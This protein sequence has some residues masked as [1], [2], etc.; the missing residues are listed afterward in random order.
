[1]H[2]M[3]GLRSHSLFVRDVDYILSEGEVIIFDEHTGRTM[4]G[5]RCSDGSPQAVETQKG[6]EIHNEKQTQASITFQNYFRLYTK[7]S[8]MTRTAAGETFEF[9]SIFTL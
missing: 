5:R 3:A 9:S 6:V 2:V 1:H 7:L 8:G 4:Q